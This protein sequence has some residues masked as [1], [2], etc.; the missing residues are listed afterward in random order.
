MGYRVFSQMFVPL[1]RGLAVLT[2]II[3]ERLYCNRGDG[4]QNLM[5]YSLFAPRSCKGRSTSQAR[6]R[7]TRTRWHGVQA[8]G[9]VARSVIILFFKY[10]SLPRGLG[11]GACL[12]HSYKG[13]QPPCRI[14]TKGAHPL[15]NSQA[16]CCPASRLCAPVSRGDYAISRRTVMNNAGNAR[17]N[18]LT[19]GGVSSRVSTRMLKKSA[20][21]ETLNS[22]R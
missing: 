6:W 20:S 2:R 1:S 5:R 10:A 13:G 12:A 3:H 4:S 14:P 8:G 21:Q 15:R 22:E 16:E 7:R 17:Q 9:L 19:V 11:S 18:R